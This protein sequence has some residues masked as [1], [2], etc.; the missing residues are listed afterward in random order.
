MVR[1]PI[2]SRACTGGALNKIQNTNDKKKSLINYKM[3]TNINYT[4][5]SSNIGGRVPL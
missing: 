3:H 1:Y 4:N 5:I 2:R